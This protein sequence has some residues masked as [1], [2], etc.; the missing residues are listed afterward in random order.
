MKHFFSYF[1]VIFVLG[2]LSSC[3]SPD[4]PL[5][6]QHGYQKGEYLYRVHDEYLFTI[7]PPEAAQAQVYPWEKNVIGGCPKITKEF[8][9]CK[10]SGLN[11]EHVVQNEKETK[12]FYDCGGKHSL[13]LREGEEF[14]YPVLIDLLNH[15]QAKT[16]SKVV[17]TCGHSCPDHHA[18]SDQTPDNRYSKHMIG[19]EVAFYVQG[20]ENSPEVIIDLIKDF[21]KNEP[22]YL[23]KN[24]YTEFKAYEK[25]D[26]NVVTRPIYN[27]E[28]YIKIFKETEGRNFDNRHPYP[29]IAIQVR[30]DFDQKTKVA[31]SWNAAYRNYLRW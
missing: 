11:P 9:R 5:D 1:L 10:G 7:H 28:I 24:E 2:I 21:Y 6:S 12:R 8:F 4:Q 16:N 23:N 17:I 3:S 30:H 14:I 27:K 15:I 25:D 20:M 26:T 13:P 19:A 29:Y 22:K 31:Y 18:Y